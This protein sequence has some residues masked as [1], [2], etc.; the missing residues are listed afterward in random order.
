MDCDRFGNG[1]GRDS[2]KT[3]LYDQP[4]RCGRWVCER[5]NGTYAAEDSTAIGLEENG[6]LIWGVYYN[7]YH[8]RSMAIH[9]ASEPGKKF[10]REFL[11]FT[12]AYPFYQLKVHKLIGLVDEA[13]I[14]ARKFDE[15]LGFK[16]ETRIK[17]ASPGGDLLI[18]TMTADE[19]RFI[20]N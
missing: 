7:M 9:V 15:N 1:T 3:I 18:Y 4:E 16:L 14:E 10:T 20:R 13:N 2:L 19:C 12:F 6:S 5:I 17:D 8:G 11:R